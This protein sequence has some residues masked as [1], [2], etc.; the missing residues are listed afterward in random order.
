[1]FMIL[2]VLKGS[3]ICCTKFDYRYLEH[4][5]PKYAVLVYWLFWSLC[6]WKTPNS[7][8]SFLWTP[9]TANS[10]KC[11]KRNSAVTSPSRQTLSQRYLPFILLR[12]HSSVLKFIYSPLRG[13]HSPFLSLL[14]W[15]LILKSKAISLR[16]AHYPLGISRIHVSYMQ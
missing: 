8:R 10:H 2:I 6:I 5:K 13:L 15:Y 4:A 16:V 12:V 3:R 9:L 11:L 7:G 1:M 14:S